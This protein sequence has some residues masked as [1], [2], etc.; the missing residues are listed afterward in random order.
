[1]Y[2]NIYIYIYIYINLH[3]HIYL[4]DTLLRCHLSLGEAVSINSQQTLPDNKLTINCT[5]ICTVHTHWFSY[6]IQC[7]KQILCI[8]LAYRNNKLNICP[9]LCHNSTLADRVLSGG[10]IWQVTTSFTYVFCFHYSVFHNVS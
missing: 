7:C 2:I 6:T 1:M 4:I 10:S 5:N 8:S 9:A 3:I